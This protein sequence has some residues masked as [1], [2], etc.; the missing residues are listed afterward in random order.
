MREENIINTVKNNREPDDV[1]EEL[2][3]KGFLSEE[4]YLEIK[5][6]FEDLN[7]QFQMTL[8]EIYKKAYK[9]KRVAKCVE[10]I[11]NMGFDYGDKFR[12]VFMITDCLKNPLGYNFQK[13][14]YEL[15]MNIVLEAINQAEQKNYPKSFVQELRQFALLTHTLFKNNQ[16]NS[17]RLSDNKLGEYPLSQQIRMICIFIQD[18]TRLLQNNMN[19]TFKEKD[20]L[21]GMEMMVSNRKV[22]HFE[23]QKVSLNDNYEGMLEYFDV[24]IRYL[25][26]TKRKQLNYNNTESHGDI[27]PFNIPSFEEITYIAMQRVMYLNME[28]KFRYSQWELSTINTI[29]KK[30]IVMLKPKYLEKYRAHIIA[31]IRRRY[32]LYTNLIKKTSI[33]GSEA[34]IEALNTLGGMV[35]IYCFEDNKVDYELYKK[36]AMIILPIIQ[37]YKSITKPF[38]LKC[39][40]NGIQV[41]DVISAYEFLY[42]MSKIYITGVLNI[43]E[44]KNYAHYKYL[45]PIIEIDYLASELARLYNVSLEYSKKLIFC[46]VYDDS[47]RNDDG[48]IFS[49]PLIKI[50]KNKILLCETLID[51]INLER[52]IEILLLKYNV[53]LAPMG[54]EFE[55]KLIQKLSCVPRIKVNTNHVVFQAYDGKDVEFDFIGTLDDFLLLFEF[56]SVVTPYSD[57]QLYKNEETIKE[58]VNQVLRRCEIVQH[59]WDKIS[60]LVNIELPKEPY[61][62]NKI[63]KV[64]CTNIFDF[65]TLKYKG[66]RITDES[67]LLKYFTDPYVGVVSQGIKTEVV[68]VDQIWKTGKPTGGEFIEYLDNPVTIG[69]IPSCLKENTKIIPAFDGDIPM[70]FEDTVLVE[71]PYKRMIKSKLPATNKEK[72]GR[73]DSCPCGSGKKYKRC[74]GK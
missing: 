66:V 41:E 61:N 34:T 64:V 14:D 73:N 6:K 45:V 38:Y 52:C 5:S 69:G 70:A 28:S 67:T 11:L 62:D 26:A 31:G 51:Q 56:K 40:F 74:C 48:D 17:K 20:F 47:I 49:R 4:Q 12:K 35:N 30:N 25:Y 50:S 18:Q 32:R 58:G 59:D 21:T 9:N 15:T 33:N 71:D 68:H 60:K 16:T 39:T 53:D 8:E 42:T 44:E 23:N 19:K 57:K 63:I 10:E 3:S 37:S 7:D 22:D 2:R 54:K 72:F 13:E 1:L 65:T 36:A 43:F 27:H 46:F 55:K 29:D 24:L